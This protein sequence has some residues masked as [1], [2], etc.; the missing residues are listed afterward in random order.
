MLIFI[1][2]RCYIVKEMVIRAYYCATYQPPSSC[3]LEYIRWKD[4]KAD[5]QKQKVGLRVTLEKIVTENEITAIAEEGHPDRVCLGRVLARDRNIGYCDITMPISER[6]RRGIKT[7]DYDKHVETRTAAYRGFEEFMFVQTKAQGSKTT[8]VLCGRRHLRGLE[9]LF[10]A[11]GD[12]VKVYD[13]ND[14]DWHRGRPMESVDGIIG[15]D[16]EED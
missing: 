9:T 14:Y 5:E 16:R 6:E 15:Y 2:P 3:G 12:E 8:L 4:G 1:T 7:P 10:K 11:A 13:I